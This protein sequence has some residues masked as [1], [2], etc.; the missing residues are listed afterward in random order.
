[1]RRM[2]LFAVTGFV[3]AGLTLSACG[4]NSLSTSPARRQRP[5]RS[6]SAAGG[7]VDQALAAKLPAKIKSAGKIVIGTDADLRS[8]T[9]TS[10]P[11]ARP[12][13]GMDVDALRRRRGQVRPQDRVGPRRLRRDHPRRARAASTTSASR[14]SPSTPTARSRSTWSATS[15]PAPS[16]SS[17]EG[18]PQE[19]Q[20]RRRLRQERRRAEGHR[21]GRR[22]SP[23]AARS[24]PTP[25]SPTSTQLVQT[26]TRTKVTADVAQSGKAD[27][28]L[29]DPPSASYAVEQTGGTLEPLGEHLRLGPLRLR[30]PKDR[31]RLRRRPSSRP[32]RRSRPTAPT[33]RP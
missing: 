18:Q 25:A 22:T 21:A 10:T 30:V 1:M 31:D 23:R 27:A 11:T 19:G 7:G 32:S 16:G 9:S 12:S 33:R 8:P 26:P 5:G 13:I 4:S 17:P 15:R 28:M 3:A 20:P 24:A 29:A 14:A 6:A 2:S